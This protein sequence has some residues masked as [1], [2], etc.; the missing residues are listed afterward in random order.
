MAP[1]ECR[2]GPV[3]KAPASEAGTGRIDS[4]NSDSVFAAETTRTTPATS[5]PPSPIRPSRLLGEASRVPIAPDDS[6]K[7]PLGEVTPS[8]LRTLIEMR[9]PRGNPGSV[10]AV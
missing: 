7:P 8:G 4:G 1:P 2:L 9:M 10:G 5:T 3:A 6:S